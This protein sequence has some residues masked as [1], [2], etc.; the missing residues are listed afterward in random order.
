MPDAFQRS[1]PPTTLPAAPQGARGEKPRA[2]VLLLFAC[3]LG[4]SL[5]TSQFS[6]NGP[7]LWDDLHL[8][9]VRTPQELA[10]AWTETWD[11]D[12]IETTGFRPLTVTFD[13]LRALT[14][15]ESVVGHR[16]FLIVLFC[17]YL[18]LTGLLAQRLFGATFLL[19]LLAG[20]LTFF[21]LSS[22]YHYFWITDGIYLLSGTLMLGAILSLGNALRS[23]RGAW[24]L[25]AWLCSVLAL[26]TREDSLT[27]YP[28]LLWFG[29]AFA[30]IGPEGERRIVLRRV[31]LGLFAASM[32]AAL[33]LYWWWRGA[34]V[35]DAAELT[36]Q[37]RALLWAA[38]QV[39]HNAGDP[40]WLVAPW[41]PYLLAIR[42]W[43][44]WLGA[45]AVA[46][47]VAL[48]RAQR[49]QMLF[50][51]ATGFVSALPLM[52]T[53]RANLLLLPVTFWGLLVATALAGFLHQSLTLAP[54]TCAVA[55]TV[56]AVAAP[57]Y[58]SFLFQ[59]EQQPGNLAWVCGNEEFIYGDWSHATIPEV[60]RESVQTE[61]SAY[62][63]SSSQHFETLWRGLIRQARGKGRIGANQQGLTFIPRFDF[64][65]LYAQEWN[66]IRLLKTK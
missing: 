33:A 40:G 56:L 54:R 17:V 4:I 62:G 3:L 51:A 65:P 11:T 34:A 7:F 52:V 2:N 58:A 16:I 12:H 20:L 36:L 42:L 55:L 26:L 63:I 57:A 41:A 48:R 24:L 27:I 31:A 44:I 35:P 47:L 23:G 39:V 46:A 64:M 22:V 59:Q 1:D 45:L 5:L 29:I 10:R 30:W 21:H 50:W 53:A 19:M 66:C 6:I 8:I 60:R 28:L 49:G 18:T 37:P 14:F 9:R 61:L 43:N 38:N 32:L 15:G 25:A 13:H